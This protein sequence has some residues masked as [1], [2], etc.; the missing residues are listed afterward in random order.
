M[1]P[2]GRALVKIGGGQVFV[3]LRDSEVG[4]QM[5]RDPNSG[6]PLGPAIGDQKI[7]FDAT[8]YRLVD[9]TVDESDDWSD[10]WEFTVLIEETTPA[11]A[12]KRRNSIFLGGRDILFVRVPSAL[13]P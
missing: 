4:Y 7:V 8:S 3:M 13:A 5:V 2:M 10:I 6:Q 1:S 12:I 11:G 9:G